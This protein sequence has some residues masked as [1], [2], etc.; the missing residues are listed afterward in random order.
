MMKYYS[1]I[2]TRAKK[3]KRESCL[4]SSIEKKVENLSWE[5]KIILYSG[6]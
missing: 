2:K 6:M 3:K 5:G 4:T 1:D